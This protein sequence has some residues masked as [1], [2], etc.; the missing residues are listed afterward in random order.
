[1]APS[2]KFN[3]GR[4]YYREESQLLLHGGQLPLSALLYMSIVHSTT[5]FPFNSSPLLNPEYQGSLELFRL[6]LQI[7]EY[8]G[9]VGT[10][11][12]TPTLFKTSFTAAYCKRLALATTLLRVEANRV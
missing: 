2:A 5:F 11:P 12:A 7:Q 4:Q 8:S 3:N 10:I 9:P 6:P 1:M